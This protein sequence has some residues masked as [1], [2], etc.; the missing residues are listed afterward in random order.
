MTCQIKDRPKYVELYLGGKLLGKE[1]EQFEEHIF[2]CDLC[3]QELLF[4]QETAKVIAAEGQ[5]ILAPKTKLE[6]VKQRLA[7]ALQNFVPSLGDVRWNHVFAYASV[8]ALVLI[9]SYFIFNPLGSNSLSMNFDN[10]VPYKFSALRLRGNSGRLQIDPTLD[11]FV[12]NFE[13][14]I[15]DYN[16]FEYKSAICTFDKLAPLAKRILQEPESKARLPWVRDYY[17][18]KGLSHLAVA[19]A[20]NTSHEIKENQISIAV[21]DIQRAIAISQKYALNKTDREN[22]FLMMA[23]LV[24][25]DREKAQNVLKQIS[26]TSPFLFKAKKLLSQ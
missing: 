2:E 1:K 4:Q 9:G 22:Y 25:G 10:H 17:F 26:E 15:G 6:S 13:S 20:K 5:R 21:E 8:A 7:Q 3:F 14:A 19:S 24:K 23:L 18:Y 11:I 12:K 16:I